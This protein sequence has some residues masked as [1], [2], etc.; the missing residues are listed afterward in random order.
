MGTHFS[1]T[2][3]LSEATWPSKNFTEKDRSDIILRIWLKRKGV[4]GILD[5]LAS[6]MPLMRFAKKLQLTL[7]R[8]VPGSFLQEGTGQ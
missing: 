4:K 8:A 7:S 6:G 2:I 5:N 3:A 1:L